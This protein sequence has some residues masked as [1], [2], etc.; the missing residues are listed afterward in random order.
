[1]SSAATPRTAPFV[2]QKLGRE[3]LVVADDVVEAQR[4][5]E[6]RVE[7]VEADLVGRVPGA[8]GRHA[9][10][11]ARRDGPVLV[12]T[13]RA[14]PVFEQRQL[15]RRL[16]DEVRMTSWSPRKSEPLTVS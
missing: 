12:A 15:P 8:L 6:E 5:L 16:L 7:H 2:D 14:A 10:E 9:A 13:P 4:V 11:R 3:M 1:M